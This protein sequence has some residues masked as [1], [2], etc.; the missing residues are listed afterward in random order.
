MHILEYKAY[1][2]PEIAAG[3]ALD[4]NTAEDLAKRGNDVHLYIPTPSRGISE[5]EAK[6][7]PNIEKL[8]SNHL[9]IYRYKMFREKKNILFRVMRYIL[10][11]VQQIR[12]GLK[13]KNIDLIFAG[14]T[15]PF[16]GLI[17]AFLKKK[18][19]IPFV[20]NCQDI[21]PDSMVSAKLTTDKSV[22]FKIGS[23]ISQVIY[24]NAD[25]II[26]ISNSMKENLVKKGVNKDKIEI[27]PNW[28][29]EKVIY[30]IEKDKN[31]LIEKL[32]I[33]QK[34]FTVVYAGNLGYA[35]SIETILD[36]AEMLKEDDRIGIVIFGDG[37]LKENVKA[38]I[39]D[40]RL[41]NVSLYPLQPYEDVSKVYSLGDACIV[42]C[43]KGTSANAMPSK[44][45]SIMGCGKAV[46]ASFDKNSELHDMLKQYNCGMFSESDNPEELKNNIIKLCNDKDL[47]REQ[48][49]NSREYIIQN[50]TR[51]KCTNKIADI[52]EQTYNE[53]K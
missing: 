51:Q 37:V 10:C 26:V 43:K 36:A 15:P 22:I 45:W 49:E 13:E 24:R 3:I 14:S 30:P 27:V 35:Q 4:S 38:M 47:C 9:H 20:Y 44:T 40:K 29:D 31:T 12:Y 5:Q 17:C 21:F 53:C 11:S 41:D 2:E 50:L 32:K 6:M 23:K 34:E 33:P 8:C 52:I 19:K 1:Y 39:K 42:S 16:Q 28:I 48:G 7:V 18:K 25:K 46:L